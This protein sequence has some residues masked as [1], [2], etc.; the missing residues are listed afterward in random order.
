[1]NI[2]FE[3]VTDENRD[4]VIKLRTAE[5]QI[6]FV[7]DV[8]ECLQEADRYHAWRPVGIFDGST[9]IG[10]AM[11]GFFWQYLP[12]GRVWLD[13]LL[14]DKEYQGRGY[15]KEAVAKLLDRLCRE[16]GRS[17]I[18]LSVYKENTAAIA[19]YEQF[20]FRFNG[21]LDTKGEQIMVYKKT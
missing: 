21:K 5:W 9:L 17:K 10:F 2:H 12:F 16:Y 19:L 4:D 13:R 14:V 15:G 20:G 7:E 1:M 8:E 3:P 18:Y 6:S 11:Y